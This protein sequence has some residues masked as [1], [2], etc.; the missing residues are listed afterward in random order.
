MKKILSLI[1]AVSLLVL[2]VLV[3]ADTVL[4]NPLRD[5][6]VEGLISRI[7]GFLYWV[8]LSI[9]IIVIVIAG[10]TFIISAGDP[11][12]T[13]KAKR[14]MLYTI[15]GVAIMILAKGLIAVITNVLQG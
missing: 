15:I 9:A 10:I 4:P 3:S 12:K 13:E 2:P 5:S 8:G 14:I 11:T 6:T 1:F 7:A